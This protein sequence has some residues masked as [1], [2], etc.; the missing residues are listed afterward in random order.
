MS[1]VLVVI[2]MQPSFQ[3]AQCK[4]TIL[5]CKEAIEQAMIDNAGLLF[6]EYVRG[7]K[8]I[9]SLYKIAKN[10]RHMYR[11]TKYADDGCNEVL[12]AIRH[13]KL[14]NQLI[15]FCG[16]HTGACVYETVKSIREYTKAELQLIKKACNDPNGYEYVQP[17][18]QE[19]EE[20][21]I[22]MIHD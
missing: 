4:K 1:Y 11:V 20:M 3:A 5:A 12:A 6:V 15:R 21:G 14:P 17:I 16:V 2:D 9:P 22:E 19:L 10:Y 18:L 7:G 13:Y 8:T